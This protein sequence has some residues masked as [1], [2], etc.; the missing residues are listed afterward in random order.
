MRKNMTKNYSA[1]ALEKKLME[2]YAAG[3]RRGPV[4]EENSKA[5]KLTGI[6]VGRHY[7][8]GI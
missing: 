8:T 4:G 2:L 7:H 1:Q 3:A 5:F 6:G